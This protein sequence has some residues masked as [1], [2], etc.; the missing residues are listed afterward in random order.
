MCPDYTGCPHYIG[1]EEGRDTV[2]EEGEEGDR[3]EEV[4]VEKGE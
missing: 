4:R 3:K 2:V 1:I